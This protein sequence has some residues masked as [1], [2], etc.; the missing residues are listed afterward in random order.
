MFQLSQQVSSQG[1]T[2]Q[3][4]AGAVPESYWNLWTGIVAIRQRI[5]REEKSQVTCFLS[6]CVLFC[7]CS[8]CY[9]HYGQSSLEIQRQGVFLQSLTVPLHCGWAECKGNTQVDSVFFIGKLGKLSLCSICVCVFQLAIE[10]Y[11]EM[12][13]AFSDSRELKLLKVILTY[14][15]P[16]WI[17]LAFIVVSS[18]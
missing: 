15:S 10:K 1:W 6:I 16:F 8:G 7:F 13:P 5:V 2:L 9:E 4:S 12:F 3:R 17:A 18:K 11:E 14:K